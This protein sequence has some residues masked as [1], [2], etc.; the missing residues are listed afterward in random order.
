[1]SR[2]SRLL[3]QYKVR[4]QTD[5]ELARS[6]YELQKLRRQ[7]RVAECGMRTSDSGFRFG[8][9]IGQDADDHNDFAAA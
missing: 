2:Q 3:S 9:S 6:Y 7:V 8:R 1:M 5:Q 4:I